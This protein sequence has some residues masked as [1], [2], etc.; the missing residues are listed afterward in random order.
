[1]PDAAEILVFNLSGRT[2]DAEERTL[3]ERL[4]ALVR[5]KPSQTKE[6]QDAGAEGRPSGPVGELNENAEAIG[7]ML[8]SE[9]LA[10]LPADP[11]LAVKVELR[12]RD[13]SIVMVGTAA[14][15]SWAGSVILESVRDEFAEIVKIATQ[16][17]IGAAMARFA[18][19]A[20]PMQCTVTPRRSAAASVHPGAA[21]SGRSMASILP[22][23]GWRNAL[24]GVLTLAVLL[25][26]VD[27]FLEVSLRTTRAPIVTATQTAQPAVR[28]TS[29]GPD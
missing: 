13:G 16:R 18:R 26:L 19:G 4:A 27:R 20:G 14:I 6:P 29:A 5:P 15:L 8:E 17:V 12:F 24:T 7:K 28:S 9:I 2:R 1:M 25:L 21:T 22:G 10:A 3:K 23:L 11:S